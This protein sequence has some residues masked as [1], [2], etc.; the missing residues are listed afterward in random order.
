MEDLYEEYRGS[1]CTAEAA[2]VEEEVFG[3]LSH[4]PES[5]RDV[6]FVNCVATHIV[7]HGSYP[8]EAL[9]RH[10][11]DPIGFYM[12]MGYNESEAELLWSYEP[13]GHMTIEPVDWLEQVACHSGMLNEKIASAVMQVVGKDGTQGI[14]C[15]QDYV[16]EVAKHIVDHDEY[17]KRALDK[18][19]S[20]PVGFYVSIGIAEDE[21]ELLWSLGPTDRPAFSPEAWLEQV[22]TCE[23][24]LTDELLT[25]VADHVTEASERAQKEGPATEGSADRAE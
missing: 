11:T 4:R 21:A 23:G 6:R 15:E 1:V 9:E 10:Q 2:R 20:D 13:D 16:S 7:E 8:A 24:K 12:C 25:A 3:A 18:F 22:A 14:Q 19:T 5:D 17:P